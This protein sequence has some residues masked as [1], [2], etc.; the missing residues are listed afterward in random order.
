MKI[1]HIVSAMEPHGIENLVFSIMCADVKNVYIL[2]IECSREES[3]KK[4]PALARYSSNLIFA[5]KKNGFRYRVS[6]LIKQTCKKHSISVI[7]THHI[8]PLIYGGLASQSIKSL[9][10]VHTQHDIWH[11]KDRKQ[12]LIEYFI[13]SMRKNIHLTAISTEIFNELNR[14]Y[15]RH[16]ISLIY[17][18]IDTDR[19]KPGNKHDT[20]ALLNLPLSPIIIACV[21]R[22]EEIKGQLYLI[23]AMMDLPNSYYL[24]IAGIGDLS[25]ALRKATETLGLSNRVCFLGQIEQIEL[26]Y[27]AS[28][29]FCLPSLDEG[30]PLAVLEAQACNVPVICSNVGSCAEGVDPMSGRLIAPKDPK[31]IVSAC[32]ELAGS[33]KLPRE[34]ILLHF[35]LTSIVKKYQQIY[36][37]S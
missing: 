22:L 30:L 34:Y 36:E 23:R 3:Y 29:L 8:G 31:A 35:S 25:D 12:W 15:P 28:D 27:Q 11:I 6:R 2:A 10:H 32:L 20:R 13:L 4:W 16:K 1:L 24:A 18:G 21:G 19:F 14:L 33:N 26:L 37:M 17:N 7:H 5:H 9:K